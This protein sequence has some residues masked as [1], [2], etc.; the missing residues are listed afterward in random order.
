MKMGTFYGIGVGPGDPE[1]ITV[2]AINILK[3]VNVVCV[4][5]K[6]RKGKSLALDIARAY[7]PEGVEIVFLNFPMTCDHDILQKCW[8][9]AANTIADRLA[10]GIDVAYLTLGD[11]ALYSTYGYVKDK[12]RSW[13]PD[14]KVCTVPGI[15]SVSAAAARVNEVLASGSEALLIAPALSIKGRQHLLNSSE[16][17]AVLKA[18]RYSRE[19][20]V[21]LEENGFTKGY[22]V[23]NLGL[24][25]EKV[26]ALHELEIDGDADYLTLILAKK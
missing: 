9:E 12:L 8:E 10:L 23:S 20:K 1:L 24:K 18:G 15:S 3:K 14:L 2:K 4:P 26:A 19:L 21:I 13:Y 6:D 22:M 5:E 11:P 17:V 16:S 25:D 7:L